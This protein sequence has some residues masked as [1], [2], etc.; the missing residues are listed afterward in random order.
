MTIY[1]VDRPDLAHDDRR[2][3]DSVAYHCAIQAKVRKGARAPDRISI[4]LQFFVNQYCCNRP[5]FNLDESN[6]R[7]NQTNLLYK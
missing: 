5:Y 2:V 7:K 3:Q 6:K 4:D 1:E